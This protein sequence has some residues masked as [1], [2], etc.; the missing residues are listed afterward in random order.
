M[1]LIVLSCR[2]KTRR[3]NFSISGHYGYY[4][5]PFAMQY[6]MMI[7]KIQQPIELPPLGFSEPQFGQLESEA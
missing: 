4:Q 7:A 2:G 6:R 5:Q 1:P 3:N